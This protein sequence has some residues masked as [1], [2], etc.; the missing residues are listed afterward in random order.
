MITKSPDRHRQI[1]SP[2]LAVAVRANLSQHARSARRPCHRPCGTGL[3]TGA[4]GRQGI[5]SVVR[6][7]P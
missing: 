5:E 4:D 6:R 7:H 1:L 3:A 2:D